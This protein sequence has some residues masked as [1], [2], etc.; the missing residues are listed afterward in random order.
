M[1]R[2][3]LLVTHRRSTGAQPVG[4]DVY[5]GNGKKSADGVGADAARVDLPRR[6]PVLGVQRDGTVR[7]FPAGFH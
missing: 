3:L 5:L 1:S 4:V 6:P 2:H 7:P